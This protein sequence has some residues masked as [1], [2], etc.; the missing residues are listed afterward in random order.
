MIWT[1]LLMCVELLCLTLAKVISLLRHHAYIIN[2]DNIRIKFNDSV[3]VFIS[4]TR[5]RSW[6]C[7]PCDIASPRDW[8]ILYRNAGIAGTD[9]MHIPV[10]IITGTVILWR[11]GVTVPSN[12]CIVWSVLCPLNILPIQADDG[13][14]REESFLGGWHWNAL[15]T[16]A[17]CLVN[18]HQISAYRLLSKLS[19]MKRQLLC[20]LICLICVLWTFKMILIF[21]LLYT[22]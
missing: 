20:V 1:G 19:G 11:E 10:I 3:V 13:S 2:Q 5:Y 6:I 15:L 4:I 12:T 21:G 18:R 8:T 14:G 9:Q 22:L 16:P 7:R 17:P